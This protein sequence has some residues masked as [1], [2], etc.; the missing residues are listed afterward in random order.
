MRG[1]VSTPLS[2][3]LQRGFLGY[4]T[5]TANLLRRE[6]IVSL[7]PQNSLNQL[8]GFDE[9]VTDVTT[10]EVIRCAIKAAPEGVSEAIRADLGQACR[11]EV[12]RRRVHKISTFYS[13]LPPI[14]S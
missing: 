7:L 12:I 2:T 5:S 6:A 3:Q 14:A 1:A 8:D 13:N 10:V 11:D 9:R 4:C